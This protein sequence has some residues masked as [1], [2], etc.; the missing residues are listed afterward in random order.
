[1]QVLGRSV[2]HVGRSV[3]TAEIGPQLVAELHGEFVFG[4]GLQ[5]R[6]CSDGEQ[7]VFNIRNESV[8]VQRQIRVTRYNLWWLDRDWW[9]NHSTG[10]FINGV[11]CNGLIVDADIGTVQ[12]DI[13]RRLEAL[14]E[15]IDGPFRLENSAAFQKRENLDIVPDGDDVLWQAPFIANCSARAPPVC[16]L[17]IEQSRRQ[18]LLRTI[19]PLRRGECG[20]KHGRKNDQV[21]NHC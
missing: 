5:W 15:Y 13:G 21:P 4:A 7:F 19:V 1:M 14:D 6:F 9:F 16:L 2:L 8:N 3:E 20:G 11:Y 12:G 18:R 17:G 10:L